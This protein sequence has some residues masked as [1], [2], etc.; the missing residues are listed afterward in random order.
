MKI[1]LDLEN[2]VDEDDDF[3]KRFENDLEELV[4]DEEFIENE[5]EDLELF[6]QSGFFENLFPQIMLIWDFSLTFLDNKR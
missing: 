4:D 3:R 5:D 6:D 2:L 1:G